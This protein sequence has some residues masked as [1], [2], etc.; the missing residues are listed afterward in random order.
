MLEGITFTGATGLL[1][2]A[3]AALGTAAAAAIAI[4]VMI[5]ITKKAWRL[6]KQFLG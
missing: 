5:V 6:A 1:G 2:G 4:G 3:A